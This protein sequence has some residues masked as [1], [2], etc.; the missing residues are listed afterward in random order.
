MPVRSLPSRAFVRELLSYDDEDGTLIWRPR[1]RDLFA[2]ERAFVVWNKRFPG[3]VAGSPAGGRLYL[4][5][6]GVNYS[7]HRLIWLYV[8]GEPVPP[9]IDHRDGDPSNNNI[10]N[11]RAATHHQNMANSRIKSN[12]TSGFKGVG[13]VMNGRFRARICRNGKL[14]HL[15]C[16]DT[17]EEAAAVRR[18]VAEASDGEFVC[19]G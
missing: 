16:F 10:N 2:N 1:C 15:G 19:H 7:V 14:V 11:L 3:T 6:L 5:V 18:K 12:N 8:N 13:L 9:E 4:R 17:P